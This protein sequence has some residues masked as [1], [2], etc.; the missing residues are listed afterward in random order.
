MANRNISIDFVKFFA[1]FLVMNSHMGI[2]YPK[3]E[4]LSTGG[5][6]GDALFFFASGFTIFL[7]KTMRFDNWYKRRINRIYPSLI[8]SAI[9]A[10]VLFGIKD[11]I[12]EILLGS[13]YW[14]IGC[15]LVYYILLYPI[16]TFKVERY[17]IWLGG[18]VLVFI[19]FLFYNDGLSIYRGGSTFRWFAYFLIMLQGAIMGKNQ[20]KYEF[21]YMYVILLILSL[22]SWYALCYIGRNN[23]AILLS[24]IPLMCISRYMYL[25]CCAPLLSGLYKTK[26]AGK[27]IYIISQLCLESYLIQKFLI[28]GILNSLFPLNIPLMMFIILIAAYITK[29]WQ[30]LYHRP[31]KLSHT[32]GIK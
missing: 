9:F 21:R 17:M 26:I 15:I 27:V 16:K 1:I 28:S 18:A 6:I 31:S 5:A 23:W 4:F 24:W 8:A 22:V 11:N 20:D 25:T 10:L 29:L 13:R 7:G 32:S 30:N 2:C 14:F 19:Y 12:G 3:Y